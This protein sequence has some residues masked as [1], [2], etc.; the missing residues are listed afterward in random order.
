ML[1]RPEMTIRSTLIFTILAGT[2]YG[3]VRVDGPIE[4]NGS[5]PSDRQVQGLAGEAGPHDAVSASGIQ[6]GQHVFAEPVSGTVLVVD[7]PSLDAYPAPGT[8]ILVRMPEVLAPGNLLIDVNTWGAY[9]VLLSP[10]MPLQQ[11]NVP[12]GAILS[13]VFD[14][15]SFQVM[16]GSHFVKRTCPT[17]MREMNQ[18]YCVDIDESTDPLNFFE[19]SIVCAQA[20]KRLCTWAE[21]FLACDRR[22]EME[23][24][25]MTTNYH[26]W[27]NSTMNGDEFVRV[28]GN[29][30]CTSAGGLHS[31]NDSLHFRCCISR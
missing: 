24:L 27:T 12:E 5:S 7:L 18:Q 29:N 16:N 22:V 25:N 21:L 8:H 19:A 28:M 15:A 26:E 11:E 10:G 17:N 1:L 31:L 4:L 20:G 23:L 30:S 13:L 2:S 14:G 3:Q 9:P 6:S